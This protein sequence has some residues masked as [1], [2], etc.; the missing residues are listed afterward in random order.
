MEKPYVQ[1]FE[2]SA[3]WDVWTER[4]NKFSEQF[5]GG[6]SEESGADIIA[7]LCSRAAIL[8]FYCSLSVNPYYE[9]HAQLPRFEMLLPYPD[10]REIISHPENGNLAQIK[11]VRRV[12]GAI[13]YPGVLENYSDSLFYFRSDSPDVFF[14]PKSVR[15]AHDSA[16]LIAQVY[17]DDF[18]ELLIREAK[19]YWLSKTRG[20]KGFVL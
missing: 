9:P 5:F 8:Q 18:I 4:L 6:S 7:N 17:R 14:V 2:P 13:F 1:N 12:L 20:R 16:K 10:F 15:E 19:I 3:D 11:Y